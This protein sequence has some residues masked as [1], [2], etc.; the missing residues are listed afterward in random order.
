[1]EHRAKA[2][3]A[4]APLALDPRTAVP[5][6]QPNG[7]TVWHLADPSDIL[8][9]ANAATQYGF[10]QGTSTQKTFFARPQIGQGANKVSIPDPP[11]VADVGSLLG[12]TGIFPDLAK[13][14]SF[15]SPQDLVLG[16]LGAD[17]LTLNNL[18][19][20]PITQ[21]PLTLVDFSAVKVVLVYEDRSQSPAPPTEV[22]FKLDPNGSPR[23]SIDFAKFTFVLVSPFG[24]VVNP[25]LQV[26]GSAHA[27]SDSSPKLGDLTVVYGSILSLV[28]QVFSKLNE[29]ASSCRAISR[30]ST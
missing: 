16:A 12:A 17:T 6:I 1:M 2:R 11:H 20:F 28:Q 23:W 15:P 10:L 5:L 9:L 7:D 8:N 29:L 30:I 21:P 19:K 25:L 4:G 22:T 26:V 14:L 13:A 18:A 3:L 27:D 24:D